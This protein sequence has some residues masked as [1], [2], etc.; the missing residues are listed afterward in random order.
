MNS[1]MK[2]TI[3]ILLLFAAAFSAVAGNGLSERTFVT[4]DR[5]VYVAGDNVWCSAFCVDA[6]TGRLSDFS[7]MAY[8]ELHSSNAMV[9]TAK[10]ALRGG[11]G[12]AQFR[13][14]SNLPSGNYRLFAYTAQ[15]KNEQG[16]DYSCNARTITIINPYTTARVSGGVEIVADEDYAGPELP[17][18]QGDVSVSAPSGAALSS[19]IPVKLENPGRAA[20][21][22]VSVWHDDGIAAPSSSSMSGFVSSL[23]PGTEFSQCAVPEYE[24]EVIKGRIVGLSETGL[25]SIEGLSAFISAPGNSSDIYSSS[26][27]SDG[28]VTF[29][30]SNI[31][32]NKELVSEIGSKSVPEVCHIEMES[33]FVNADPGEIPVLK[34]C[35]SL[36][37]RIARRGVASQI[38]KVFE[39]DTLYDRLV[40]NPNPLFGKAS[41]VYRLDDYTRFPLISEVIV[42]YVQEMRTRKGADGAPDIQVRLNDVYNSVRYSPGQ[43]LMMIDGV[44]VFDHQKLLD[45]DPHLVEKLEI[46]PYVYYMGE[47]SFD[48]VANFVTYKRNL[49]S[50]SF[51]DNVRIVDFKGASY[52][53]VY[54]CRGVSSNPEYPDYRQTAYWHPLLSLDENGK[55]ELEVALPAY[56]GTF[57]VVVEGLTLD[58]EPIY[59]ATTVE[60]R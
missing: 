27:R 22:S 23:T 20:T 49:P 24:G 48:G 13:I 50:F 29:Y 5:Q 28:S 8:L 36:G 9:Q 12:A 39:A 25:R 19:V 38:E 7:A 59:A 1:Q 54:S 21:V 17:F 3:T 31:F 18:R 44:P 60:V 2:R 6:S 40:S 45:Y 16:F 42:E 32:G 56:S 37:D 14:P 41:K 58:G 4:T 15:N 47:R 26:I 33:P 57:K 51:A 53:V 34:M 35:P 11:R 43:S 52:P 46:Y 55:A 30:T 10:A